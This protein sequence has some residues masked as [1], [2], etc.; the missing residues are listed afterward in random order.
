MQQ[1]ILQRRFE[2]KNNGGAERSS[3]TH[4]THP[5]TDAV[6]GGLLQVTK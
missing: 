5:N 4:T 3:I 2:I 6:D 1:S